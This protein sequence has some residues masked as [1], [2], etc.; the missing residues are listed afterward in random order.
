MN[1]RSTTSRNSPGQFLDIII[2]LDIQ[3]LFVDV[4]CTDAINF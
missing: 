1:R 4:Y 3:Y 2:V